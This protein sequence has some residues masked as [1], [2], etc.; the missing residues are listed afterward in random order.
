MAGRSVELS[1]HAQT[2][3]TVLYNQT[4][5]GPLTATAQSLATPGIFLRSAVPGMGNRFRR[6]RHS[7]CDA[8][9]TPGAAVNLA[10]ELEVLLEDKLAPPNLRRGIA[11]GEMPASIDSGAAASFSPRWWTGWPSSPTTARRAMSAWNAMVA[12]ARATANP[13]SAKL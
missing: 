8:W 2:N 9:S 7:L 13:P 3:I 6:P 1:G 10:A 12:E 5:Y 4:T 11:E